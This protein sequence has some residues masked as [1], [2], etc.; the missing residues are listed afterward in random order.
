MAHRCRYSRFPNRQSK[1]SVVSWWSQELQLVSTRKIVSLSQA[2]V[3]SSV[4]QTTTVYKRRLLMLV[5]SVRS[6]RW[7]IQ[8]RK[9]VLHIKDW[10]AS[11]AGN[12]RTA[13]TLCW[14]WNK[15]SMS[16][17]SVAIKSRQ[18]RNSSHIVTRNRTR[19]SWR[20]TSSSVTHQ[21]PQHQNRYSLH[22]HMTRKAWLTN[23]SHDALAKVNLESK[24]F[25]RTQRCLWNIWYC[26]SR[27]C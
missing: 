11:L 19:P 6:V 3:T 15:F 23:S 8:Q 2:C 1:T 18:F 13:S 9:P 17:N 22:R 27:Q 26:I 4:T 20:F 5:T 14:N 21:G 10:C 24:I 7:C 25:V 12:S 16:V